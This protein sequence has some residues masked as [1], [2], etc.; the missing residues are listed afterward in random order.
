MAYSITYTIQGT[1]Y[2]LNSFDSASG[3]T[4]NYLGDLGFGMAPLHRITQRGPL[5]QGDSDVDF[6]LDPRV[7]QIPLLITGSSI[8]E[9]YAIRDKLLA[10]FSPS[11]VV[12]TLTI[13]RPD[14]SQRSIATK[15]LGGL[16][17][18]VDAKSGYNV[19]TIVQMRADDP[20]WYNP[21]QNTISGTSIITGTPT[22]IP[23]IYPVTYGA[24]GTIN[25]NTAVAYGGT[26]NSYPNIV[27]VGP[28]N[29]LVIQNTSTGDTITLAANIAALTT[30]TFDL[31]YGYKTVVDQLGANQLANITAASNLATFNL[32]PMP[33]VIGGVN[34]INIS[35]TGGTSA[36]S[37]TLTY[38]NRFI[39]V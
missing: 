18:D 33:Q 11:N 34:N 10:I 28:L 32:A 22:P 15:I 24:S 12:G 19:K 29:N 21:L 8:T 20:T 2:T 36:S 30:Y 39:G 4:F 31:R 5:Q 9:H 14:D 25:V 17:M 16:S 35:A 37:V 6:R 1:T 27:A 38:N 23:R 7:L 26:W 13:T 3:L